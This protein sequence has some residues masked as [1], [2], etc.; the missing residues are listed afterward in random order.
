MGCGSGS[1][2]C[3][4]CGGGAIAITNFLPRSGLVQSLF[5]DAASRDHFRLWHETDIQPDRRMSAFRGKAE[6]G[7]GQLDFRVWTQLR[8]RPDQLLR[9]VACDF[10]F[11]GPSQSASLQHCA[12]RV[13]GG[14]NATTRVHHAY[15]HFGGSVVAR[16]VRC[17][18]GRAEHRAAEA[19]GP[20]VRI[21][22]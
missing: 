10:S 19:P 1:N 3:C 6:V 4:R 22:L 13:L 16:H 2:R 20:F 7:A 14:V 17:T 11:A 12:R 18:R 21:R 15:R 5:R 9:S 8:H